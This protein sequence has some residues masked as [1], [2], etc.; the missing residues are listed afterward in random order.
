MRQ[1]AAL[2]AL[3]AALLTAG[4]GNGTSS[5]QP[6]GAEVAARAGAVEDLRT[7]TL[8]P[9]FAE[10]RKCET[11]YAACF[12]GPNTLKGA[13]EATVSAF[14][15]RMAVTVPVKSMHCI[16]GVEIVSCQG[17]GTFE[18]R[19]VIISVNAGGTHAMVSA[20]VF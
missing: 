16:A 20:V 7:T 5:S 18:A 8:P 3:F 19:N 1:P 10:D 2:A 15:A 9:G 6:S 12:R 13:T 17:S 14:L 4:C 11:Q